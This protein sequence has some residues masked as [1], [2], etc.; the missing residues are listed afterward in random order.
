MVLFIKV[1]LS[2]GTTPMAKADVSAISENGEEIM[3]TADDN[4]H[5]TL[6]GLGVGVWFIDAKRP[7]DNPDYEQY[8]QADTVKIEIRDT[9]EVIEL[10]DPMRWM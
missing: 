3:T 2:D 7:P 4:G 8:G 9:S 6:T 1:L 5:F 10:R